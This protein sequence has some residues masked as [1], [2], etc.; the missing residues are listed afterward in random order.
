MGISLAFVKKCN[1]K[2]L[3]SMKTF[4]ASKKSARL[5]FTLIELLATLTIMAVI[6]AILFP[7][8]TNYT[9]KANHDTAL[10]SL[11]ILQD[12]MDRYRATT[13]S[14]SWALGGS[15][16]G[17][18]LTNYALLSATDTA[19][20]LTNLSQAGSSNQTIR[21]PT[22]GIAATTNVYVVSTTG[23]VATSGWEVVWYRRNTNVSGINRKGS[24]ITN[25]SSG[26]TAAAI[27]AAF[28]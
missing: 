7:F 24:E 5:G 1:Y 25:W 23:D 20:I 8:V 22:D 2:L 13:D 12:A 19:T 10:R 3:L 28:Q 18:T 9:K 27:D 21:L 16:T 15:P 26:I 6:A 17:S 4:K 14:V 11:R